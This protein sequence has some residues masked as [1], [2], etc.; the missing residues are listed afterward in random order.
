M[1]GAITALRSVAVTSSLMECMGA[2]VF[3]FQQIWGAS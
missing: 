3:S 1:M 2:E